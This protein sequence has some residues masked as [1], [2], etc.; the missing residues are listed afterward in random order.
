[1][2]PS[3]PRKGAAISIRGLSKF[4]GGFTALEDVSLEVEPGEFMCFLGPSGSGKTTTLNLIAGFTDLSRGDIS[5]DGGSIGH[6]PAHKRNIGVVFQHYAL[7]PHMTVAG[8]VAYP[9]RQRRVAKAKRDELVHDALI[10]VQL[11]AFAHRYPSELSGGQQQRVALARAM[12]F[13]PSLLLMDEPLGALDKKLRE[14]LQLE[15]RRIHRELG[16]TFVY[17]THDQEEALVLSD[18]IAVFNKGRVEQVGTGRELY[19]RPKTLFV[20]RFIGESSVLRGR[21]RSTGSET[22]LDVG[23]QV[24]TVPDRPQGEGEHVILLRPEAVTVRPSGKKPPE[25][26]WNLLPG[27][28]S[29][30][31]YLGSAVKYEVALKT[32]G[33]VTARMPMSNV[34]LPMGAPVDL[35]WRP[36]EGTLLA[37]DGSGLAI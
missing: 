11:E 20:G 7:F 14:T 9:L 3:A 33:T 15:I 1:M 34:P 32:G 24:I 30:A 4:Y 36:D 18:R 8:N 21:H 12:V 19:T 17:V 5:L 23:E 6:V 27:N 22:A 35:C 16:S 10:K 26:R 29:E 28:V 13:D 37:D 2:M 31:I 25:G